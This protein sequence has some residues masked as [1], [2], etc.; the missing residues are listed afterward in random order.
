MA[1]TVAEALDVL[2]LASGCSQQDIRRR[3][4]ALAWELHPD[5]DPRPGAEARF[6]KI[7]AAHSVLQQD[8]EAR[9][10]TAPRPS[11]GRAAGL[12]E[13]WQAIMAAEAEL[14]AAAASSPYAQRGSPYDSS[15]WWAQA[16]AYARQACAGTDRHPETM[17]RRLYGQLPNIPDYSPYPATPAELPR[18]DPIARQRFDRM[19]HAWRRG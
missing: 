16:C 2:G 1:M 4:R 10:Q 9:A 11:D 19:Q 14:R 13:L 17:A 12:Q 7:N 8:A 3:Y 18:V 6:K 5:R 15:W